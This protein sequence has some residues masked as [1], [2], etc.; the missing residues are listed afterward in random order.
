MP[1]TQRPTRRTWRSS[2]VHDV[3]SGTSRVEAVTSTVPRLGRNQR[4]DLKER[5]ITSLLFTCAAFSTLITI[6]IVVALAG[7]TVNFFA[8]VSIVEFVTS[9][10]W[11]P[12]FTP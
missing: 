10:V 8:D 5:A 4:R 6:G 7:E 1:S 9:T 2:R 3:T 12:N 11:T